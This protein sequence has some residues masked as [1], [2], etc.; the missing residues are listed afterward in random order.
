MTDG[1]N[2]VG[3][4]MTMTRINAD[5]GIPEP[6]KDHKIEKRVNWILNRDIAALQRKY[7]ELMQQAEKER[8]KCERTRVPGS[9]HKMKY[10]KAREC[11]AMA[12]A[13]KA[14]IERIK[15]ESV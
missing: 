10:L 1:I 15:E 3:I 2:H 12:Y 7:D 6:I 9:R 4:G 8:Q 13:Y 11:L 5:T 14:V